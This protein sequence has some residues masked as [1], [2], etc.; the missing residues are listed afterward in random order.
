MAPVARL[1]AIIVGSIGEEQLAGGWHARELDGRNAV[2]YRASNGRGKFLLRRNESAENLWLLI[3]GPAG[4]AA[5]P[6]E[7]RV[8][9]DGRRHQMPLGVDTWV[10]RRYPLPAHS[11]TITVELVLENPI[12]PDR[13]L[14]NGDVRPLGWYLSAAWQE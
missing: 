10:L 1:D 2:P 12:I 11:E 7:G 8:I 4:L 3:S 9:I 6:L 14:Q 13:V 5:G